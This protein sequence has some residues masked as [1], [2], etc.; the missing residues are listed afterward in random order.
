MKIKRLFAVVTSALVLVS[1]T[2]GMNIC[3]SDSEEEI[4]GS[5][6]E[7]IDVYEELVI[8]VNNERAENGAEPI[9]LYPELCEAAEIRAEE[10][11]ESFEH[12]RP[13][14]RACSTVLD[15]CGIPWNAVGENI[16]YEWTGTTDNVMDMWMGSSGHRANILNENFTD[17]GVGVVESDGYYYWVQLFSKG[18]YEGDYIPEEVVVDYGDSNCDGK[19]DISDAVMILQAISA[20]DKYYVGGTEPTC[21][22][23]QGEIN[24]DCSG[25]GDGM[26]AKDAL[27]I[28]KYIAELIT[29]LPEE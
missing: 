12:T 18:S 29:E 26:S 27:A 6:L 19:V 5:T 7:N 10:L 21:M 11:V 17:I 22:T 8:R 23:A 24:A 3:A 1:G 14:G 28:Q 25:N 15:D 13:D 16:A 20:P 4:S 9:K 2:A